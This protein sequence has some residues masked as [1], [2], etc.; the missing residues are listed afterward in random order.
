MDSVLR[1]F[2]SLILGTEEHLI[3]NSANAWQFQGTPHPS[4]QGLL[5]CTLVM[6]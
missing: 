6:V 3:F 2:K 5:G 4:P 1:I